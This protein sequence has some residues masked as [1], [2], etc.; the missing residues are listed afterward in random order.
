VGKSLPG[1]ASADQMRLA[2]DEHQE[3]K[4]ISLVFEED[5]M[6]RTQEFVLRSFSNPDGPFREMCASNGILPRL[7]QGGR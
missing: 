4:R 3:L 2:F 7:R 1:Y 6:T 5:E